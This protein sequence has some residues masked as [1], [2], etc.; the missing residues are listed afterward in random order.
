M[1]IAPKIEDENIRAHK[2]PD[3]R[4]DDPPTGGAWRRLPAKLGDEET[5]CV[6]RLHWSNLCSLRGRELF[7]PRWS[8]LLQ[9]R[10]KV[11]ATASASPI[12]TA[13]ARTS[14]R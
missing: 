1:T 9:L 12:P 5:V 14:A 10:C 3:L 11:G 4:H 8:R 13:M 7:R 6:R 2:R